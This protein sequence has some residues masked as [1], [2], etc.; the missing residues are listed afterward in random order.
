L[1][2]AEPVWL[3][4]LGFVFSELPTGKTLEGLCRVDLSVSIRAY[5][6]AADVLAELLLIACLKRFHVCWSTP[7]QFVWTYF[8]LFLVKQ[9]CGELVF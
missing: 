9:I 6:W 4:Y 8:G 1:F 2:S 3:Q 5:E 7:R